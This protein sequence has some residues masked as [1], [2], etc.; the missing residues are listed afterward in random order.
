M[1]DR[2]NRDRLPPPS[3]DPGPEIFSCCKAGT[4]ILSSG[5]PCLGSDVIADLPFLSLTYL[6]GPLL[7]DM[8]RSNVSS[9]KASLSMQRQNSVVSGP[10]HAV[11][12]Q[13][14]PDHAVILPELLFLR[15]PK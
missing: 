15:P 9:P 12:M 2:P 14:F 1:A 13:E 11:H 4:A 6:V 10:K 3:P 8:P 5:R 7:W